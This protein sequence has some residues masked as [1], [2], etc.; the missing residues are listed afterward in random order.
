MPANRHSDPFQDAN[1]YG[2]VATQLSHLPRLNGYDPGNLLSYIPLYGNRTSTKDLIT[3][4]RLYE[5]FFHQVYQRPF[6]ARSDSI[7]L[8]QRDCLN[9]P[10]V[11]V[12]NRKSLIANK[13]QVFYN[14]DTS[15]L[16]CAPL[17]TNSLKWSESFL[18][19]VMML[20]A[21][22]KY[23]EPL[24]RCTMDF[25]WPKISLFKVGKNDYSF[26]PPRNPHHFDKKSISKNDYDIG[27]QMDDIRGMFKKK[28]LI[29]M[30]GLCIESLN[31]LDIDCELKL[32]KKGLKWATDV[33]G[34]SDILW[35]DV[36]NEIW[37]AI[38]NNRMQNMNGELISFNGLFGSCFDCV[39]NRERM[40][41]H[42]NRMKETLNKKCKVTGLT[43]EVLPRHSKDMPLYS[44]DTL[45]GKLAFPIPDNLGANDFRHCPEMVV[46]DVIRMWSEVNENLPGISLTMPMF[47]DGYVDLNPGLIGPKFSLFDQSFS[48]M[49]PRD[50][51]LNR[52]YSSFVY[53][54][55]R[56]RNLSRVNQWTLSTDVDCLNYYMT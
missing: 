3:E 9:D 13:S 28:K 36:M 12:I 17:M 26:S 51:W 47:A 31:L 49:R 53:V 32:S 41:F 52:C 5:S 35:S 10:S 22:C 21:H 2:Y 20:D 38:Q 37:C 44:F 55:D 11:Y 27:S 43:N 56:F 6:S 50:D 39:M 24:R 46:R 30:R 4:H 40:D 7:A 42:Y 54:P 23:E 19:D 33:N 29:C 1:E 48:V 45:N 18:G 16:F 15:K 14:D 8:A 25:D 34:T